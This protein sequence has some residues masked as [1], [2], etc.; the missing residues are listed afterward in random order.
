MANENWRGL[1]EWERVKWA[2]KLRFETAAAAAIAVD[3]K[4]GTYRAYERGPDSAKN[5]HLDHKHAILFGKKFGVRWEWLLTGEGGPS[6]TSSETDE[7]EKLDGE[8]EP[9]NLRVWREYR[10]LTQDE[11]ARRVGTTSTIIAQLESG[12]VEFS[13][14]WKRALAT[15]LGTTEGRLIDYDPNKVDFTMWDAFQ[16]VPPERRD[17][18]VQ[19]LKTF[20]KPNR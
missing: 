19:I 2:R 12:E 18:V 6:L 1:E 17:Q 10:G 11:L 4:D 13:D 3:M 8:G 5:I 7:P 15:A 9:N 20:K 16:E 14:K